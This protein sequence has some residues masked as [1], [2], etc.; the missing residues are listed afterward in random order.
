MLLTCKKI[1]RSNLLVS[2]LTCLTAFSTFSYGTNGIKAGAA[3]SIFL[4]TLA[5]KY[6]L[7][8][9]ILLAFLSWGFHHSMSIVLIA[10]FCSYFF[11][12]TKWYFYIWGALILA[13]LHVEFFQILF[14]G[15]TDQKGSRYLLTDEDS[16]VT[17]FRLD[18]ILY[19]AVPVIIGYLI[20]F[21]RHVND[22]IYD[23]WLR[24]YLLTNSVWMMC[25]YASFTN[26]IV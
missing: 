1:F 6:K 20:K 18:F 3:A 25:I 21:K 2:F 9:S 13:A 26:R 24:M 15:Y 14:S 12:K 11:R 17:G 22:E 19:S 8:L 7:L 10:Y 16:F 5:Y 23:L 4:C